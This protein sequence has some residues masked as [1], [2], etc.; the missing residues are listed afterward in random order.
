MWIREPD[1]GCEVCGSTYSVSPSK[2]ANSRYCSRECQDRARSKYA[3]SK[4]ELDQLY[5]GENLSMQQIASRLGFPHTKIVYWMRQY[6][7]ERRS[8]SEATTAW[9]HPDGDPFTITM[10][11]TMEGERLFGMGIALYMGEGAKRSGGIVSLSNSNPDIH[12]VFLRF[13]EEICG[14]KRSS[15][16]ATL[17]LYPDLDVEETTQWW[18]DQLGLSVEQFG[19][20]YIHEGKVGTYKKKVSH[21][22]LAVRICNT[23]LF[24]IIMRWCE[25]EY[26]KYR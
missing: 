8:W 10:P 22:T 5:N 16:G 3:P 7:I 6:G 17:Q 11:T 1:L 23:R 19:K 26:E 15:L 18:A 9:H 4:E 13:L 2:A 25:E 24:N 14:V 21:G 12:K 20:P